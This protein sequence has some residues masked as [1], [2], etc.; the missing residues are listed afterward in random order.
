MEILL[1]LAFIIEKVPTK[2]IFILGKLGTFQVIV[3]KKIIY[4]TMFQ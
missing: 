4:L 3:G 1:M 2:R